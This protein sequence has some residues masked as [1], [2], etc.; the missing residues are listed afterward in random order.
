MLDEECQF[1]RCERNGAK[2]SVFA[3]L[4]EKGEH[5]WTRREHPWTSVY[6][7]GRRRVKKYGSSDL[8]YTCTVRY[9]HAILSISC[10]KGFTLNGNAGRGGWI[11]I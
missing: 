8:A 1:P 6:V 10:D 2:F 5:P 7:Q 11:F 3:S 4:L 9:L